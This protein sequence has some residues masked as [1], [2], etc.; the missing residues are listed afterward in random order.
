MNTHTPEKHNYQKV[1]I[2]HIHIHHHERKSPPN[3]LKY[4][5]Y[6]ND[7]CKIN[8]TGRSSTAKLH[9]LSIPPKHYSLVFHTNKQYMFLLL[10][11]MSVKTSN[12]VFSSQMSNVSRQT[13]FTLH[14]PETPQ[15]LYGRLLHLIGTPLR[16]LKHQNLSVL[17]KMSN[18]TSH[19]E[20]KQINNITNILVSILSIGMHSSSL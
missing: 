20:M 17:K 16:T 8:E 5:L 9:L 11:P 12:C 6:Q 1:R 7:H 18:H 2:L 4:I 10:T 19:C 15:L 13:L 3:N 14:T